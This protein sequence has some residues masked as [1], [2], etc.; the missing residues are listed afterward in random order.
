MDIAGALCL[1]GIAL[2]GYEG[3]SPK[4][5][6]GGSG[7]ARRNALHLLT[8]YEKLPRYALRNIPRNASKVFAKGKGA[9]LFRCVARRKV[10]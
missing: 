3:I 6:R 8:F 10:R 7:V 1:L 2:C 5:Y 9:W 4:G